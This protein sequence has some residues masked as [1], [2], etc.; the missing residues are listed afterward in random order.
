M[1]YDAEV[2]KSNGPELYHNVYINPSSYRAFSKSGKFAHGTVMILELASKAVK[3]EAGLQGSFEKEFVALEASVK[4]STR[5]KEAWAY[6]SFDD[7]AGKLKAKAS[8]FNKSRCWSCHD[9]KAATDHVF[10]Q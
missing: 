2:G 9:D 3:N 5:F 1:P 8:P 7:G 10:T 4:D 6:Y